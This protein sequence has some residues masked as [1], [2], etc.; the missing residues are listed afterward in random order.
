M[1]R[2]PPYTMEELTAYCTRLETLDRLAEK[3]KRNYLGIPR[4][5]NQL[6][7]AQAKAVYEGYT[8]TLI[9]A[10]HAYQRMLDRVGK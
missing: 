4:E 5:S 3:A 6:E 7:V 9:V 10:Q 1:F 8:N 2:K